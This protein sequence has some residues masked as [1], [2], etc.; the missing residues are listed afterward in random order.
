[1]SR[2]ICIPPV[3]FAAGVKSRNARW[4]RGA[5]RDGPKRPVLCILLQLK[6]GLKN[7]VYNNSC[8]SYS[9]RCK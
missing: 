7:E 3:S 9:M 4:E 5:L 6:K 1:M 8:Y 2:L